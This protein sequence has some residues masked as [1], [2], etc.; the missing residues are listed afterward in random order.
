MVD[1]LEEEDD[2]DDEPSDEWRVVTRGGRSAPV[3]KQQQPEV[4]A[5]V[6]KMENEAR[7]LEVELL[8]LPKLT[9]SLH[10]WES[11]TRQS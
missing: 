7:A 2:S 9:S 4:V 10:G 8:A 6:A 5:T 11:L 3:A 1:N